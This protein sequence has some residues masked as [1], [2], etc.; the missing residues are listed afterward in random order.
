MSKTYSQILYDVAGHIATITL[1]RP[2][3][4]NA[5]SGTMGEEIHDA[6]LRA[7]DDEDVRA[8]ILT[9]SGDTFCVGIDLAVIEDD[10]ERDMILNGNFLKYFATCNYHCSKPTICAMNGTSVGVGI[11]MAVSFDIRIGTEDAKFALPFAKLGLLPGFGASH[12]LPGLVGRSR[13]LELVLGA[14]TIR[15][16]EALQM[17]LI[18]KMVPPGQA[19]STARAMAA[20]MAG[21]DP[22][23]L[24]MAK[25]SINF[26]VAHSLEQSLENEGTLAE[27]LNARRAAARARPS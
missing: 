1:H 10:A 23:V 7:V 4:R 2:E 25:Q 16:P 21:Y 8:I 24:A 19:L 9:G 15:G 17:G 5:F 13:A 11:T 27:V 20:A 12:L 18:D 14:G 6:F 22:T 26:G 3:K